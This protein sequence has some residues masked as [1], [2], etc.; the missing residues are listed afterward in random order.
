MPSP[1]IVVAGATGDL[2][3]RITRAL[4]D[5]GA[6]VRA[7]VRGGANAYA[8]GALRERKVD[9]VFAD[10]RRRQSIV[11]ACA[12]VHCI[13]S[14][15][16]GLRDVIVDAQTTLLGAAI[17]AGV[18]RFI[19]S[20]FCIDYNGLEPGGNRNL[21]LR[22]EFADLL[23]G[24]PIAATSILNGA[25][26]DMLTGQAPIILFKRRRVLYWGSADQ[27]M[28]FTTREDT[29]QFTAAAAMDSATPR[30]LRIAG[31]EISARG[32]AHVASDVSG[33]A[34]R[35]RKAGPLGVLNA[36]IAVMRTVAPKPGK[37][38]P[39]WQGMQYLRDMY[40]GKGK[41]HPLDN[42]R[43]GPR[44]WQTVGDVLASWFRGNR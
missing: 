41:L 2:G 21:D 3:G 13:V 11:D 30:W 19:P 8:V 4:I 20:D 14:A 44:T 38:Y 36:M 22:R 12:D 37:L 24:A 23:T 5:R 16:S 15:L 32:I 26:T 18:P 25:F 17:E 10:Y 27:L 28:D 7:I 43:Y 29:A 9:V 1:L 42:G 35:P 6:R 39:P 34:F 40:G 31:D 33:A